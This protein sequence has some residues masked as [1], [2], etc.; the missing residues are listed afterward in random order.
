MLAHETDIHSLDQLRDYVYEVLCNYDN[1]EPGMFQMTE[2]ILVRGNAPCGIHFCLHG[3]RQVKYTAI[4]ETDGNT[5]LF[6]G[7]AGE[8][9]HRTQLTEAPKLAAAN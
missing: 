8:R 6:Y 1:L 4:W 2:E 3:P 9:F 7:S 5:I